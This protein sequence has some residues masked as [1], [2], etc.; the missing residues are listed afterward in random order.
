MDLK[1]LLTYFSESETIGESREAVELMRYYSRQAQKITME[2]NTK[3]H[4]PEDIKAQ[5]STL[6]INS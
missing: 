5:L 2:I 3:Y 4:E 1:E 6:R